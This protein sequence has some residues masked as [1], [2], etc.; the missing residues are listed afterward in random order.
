[1]LSDN[2]ALGSAK[3]TVR[4][5][6]VRGQFGYGFGYGE[7]K[8]KPSPL[9]FRAGLVEMGES[10]VPITPATDKQSETPI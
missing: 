8:R 6:L 1:M 3:T 10:R 2:L 7:V 5:K 4:V 9:E